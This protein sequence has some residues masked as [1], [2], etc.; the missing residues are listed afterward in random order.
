MVHVTLEAQHIFA[1]GARPVLAVVVAEKASVDQV[2]VLFP[3]FTP[4][5]IAHHIPG[6][7][8]SDDLL[9]RCG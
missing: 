1:I 9:K 3:L 7:T 2:L 6:R 8:K 5:R 4:K